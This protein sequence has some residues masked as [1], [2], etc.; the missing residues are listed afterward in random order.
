MHRGVAGSTPNPGNLCRMS[1]SLLPASALSYLI[2]HFILAFS[3]IVAKDWKLAVG[4]RGGE[5]EGF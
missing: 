1:L 4:P 5:D 3:H 2:G